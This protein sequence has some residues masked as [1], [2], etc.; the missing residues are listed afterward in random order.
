[1]KQRPGSP[2]LPRPAPPEPAAAD[3]LDAAVHQ[4]LLK[5][6]EG[7]TVRL[8]GLGTLRPGP[9]KSVEL[10]EIIYRPSK[11]RLHDITKTGGQGC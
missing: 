1:M 11:G 4:I 3:E 6:K 8:P 10:T 9:E 2:R 7:K 5:L